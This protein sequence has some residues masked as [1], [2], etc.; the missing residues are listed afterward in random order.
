MENDSV[1]T[2]VENVFEEISVFA[3]SLKEKKA[4][5]EVQGS[6]TDYVTAQNLQ[7]IGHY[8]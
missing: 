3:E 5:V 4:G 7:S 8:G 2:I 1:E 6:C